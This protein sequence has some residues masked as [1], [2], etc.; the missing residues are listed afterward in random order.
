MALQ[1]SGSI[2]FSDITTEFGIPPAR[3][4]GAFRVSQT[5]GTLSNLPLDAGVPQSGTIRFSD[6]YSKRLNVVVDCFSLPDLTTR[7]N[8][9]GRYNDQAVVV[10]GNF[11]SRPTNSSNIKVFINANTRIGSAKGNI[12]TVALRTGDWDASTDLRFEVGPNAQIYGAG[13][14]GGNANSGGGANGTSAIGIEY[15]VIFRNLGYI[16]SGG[17]GGG[18]GAFRARNVQTGKKS[19]EF[20]VSSGGGGGGGSGWPFGTGGNSTNS[21]VTG[22]GSAGSDGAP[23][24]LTGGGG[25]GGGGT[26]AGSGGPGGSLGN[27]GS[28]GGGTAN[29]GGGPAGS[30]GRAFVISSSGSFISYTNNGTVYGGTVNENPE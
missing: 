18:A 25:G 3:N 2:S 14:N 10:I 5:A 8:A 26:D 9:R 29:A 30:G 24:S 13:G 23:G 28:G 4:L 20:S 1:S 16:Q 11:R 21:G 19:S 22:R 15:P 27:T 6:F 12:N 17:G 7:I